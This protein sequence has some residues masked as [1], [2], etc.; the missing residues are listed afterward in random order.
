VTIAPTTIS[1]DLCRCGHPANEHADGEGACAPC[2]A[3]ARGRVWGQ[4]AACRRF[5]WSFQWAG[6]APCR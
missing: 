2:A 6:G 1:Q 5:T 3:V 4:L